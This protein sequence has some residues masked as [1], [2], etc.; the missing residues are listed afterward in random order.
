[1]YCQRS[2]RK[3][4]VRVLDRISERFAGAVGRHNIAVEPKEPIVSELIQPGRCREKSAKVRVNKVTTGI[5]EFNTHE[6]RAISTLNVGV[7]H[8]YCR[9]LA[10]DHVRKCRGTPWH[11]DV[12]R[13][14]IRRV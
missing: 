14:R 11:A 6:L 9:A 1:M 5:T 12:I 8:P 13:L 3:R 4:A 7:R 2:V 10:R